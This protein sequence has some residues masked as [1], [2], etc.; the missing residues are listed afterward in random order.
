MGSTQKRLLQSQP[1]LLG[2]DCPVCFEAVKGVTFKTNGRM[3]NLWVATHATTSII[4][5]FS[6]QV[7]KE[8]VSTWKHLIHL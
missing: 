3:V 7:T 1:Q 8:T 5:L 6:L 4:R 2:E